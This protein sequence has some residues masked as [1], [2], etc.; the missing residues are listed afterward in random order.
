[1]SGA[2]L[3][4]SAMRFGRWFGIAAV[5]LLLG[6][7]I[8]RNFGIGDSLN[9]LHLPAVWEEAPAAVLVSL[10]YLLLLV[11][12]LLLSAMLITAS[13]VIRHSEASEQTTMN[14]ESTSTGF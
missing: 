4:K 7:F 5:V 10:I 1:M 2:T 9:Y 13:L 12:S 6:S 8:N 14:K 3:A 11:T